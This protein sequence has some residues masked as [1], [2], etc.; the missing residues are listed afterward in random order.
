MNNL[1]IRIILGFNALSCAFIFLAGL[2]LVANPVL[3][4]DR[5]FGVLVS[6]FALPLAITTWWHTLFWKPL[7]R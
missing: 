1:P 5:V 2:S 7:D 4:N 3:G 6:L